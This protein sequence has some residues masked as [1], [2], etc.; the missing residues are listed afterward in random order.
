MKKI[1]LAL[2][3]TVFGVFFV[4]SAFAASPEPENVQTQDQIIQPQPIGEDIDRQSAYAASDY[5]K[6]CLPADENGLPT[7]Y[8]D[9]YGGKYINDNGDFVIQVTTDDLSEYQF[10]Q[11]EFPCIVFEQVEYSYNYLEELMYEYLDSFDRDSE[12]VYSGGVN[13][14][15]NRAVI[16]VDEETFSRKT[17]DPNSPIIFGVGFSVNYTDTSDEN[18]DGSY[19]A[20]GIHETFKPVAADSIPEDEIH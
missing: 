11:D 18:A 7:A 10:L 17:N 9:T 20:Y 19:N 6:S 13:S 14:R 15:L 12:T 1:F 4:I 3:L 8:P 16:F 5:F 2:I